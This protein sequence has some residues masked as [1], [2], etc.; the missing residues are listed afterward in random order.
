MN[1]KR[2][3]LA[4]P[5]A[6]ARLDVTQE[7]GLLGREVM[8]RGVPLRAPDQA[9]SCSFQR[10]QRAVG[11]AK[12]EEPLAMCYVHGEHWKMLDGYSAMFASTIYNPT[13]LLPFQL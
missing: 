12:Q 4:W 9:S 7:E 6:S 1:H 3:G 10:W 2:P 13:V 11:E 5:R 8:D